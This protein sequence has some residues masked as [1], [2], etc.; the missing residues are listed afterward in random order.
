M[1]LSRSLSAAVVLAVLLAFTGSEVKAEIPDGWIVA[2]SEHFR[3][4]IPDR[5]KGDAERILEYAE[6]ARQHILGYT[7][8]EPPTGITFLLYDRASYPHSP[9]YA[10]S[11]TVEREIHMLA[12]SA[13]SPKD[14]QGW[15]D[16]RWYA[17]TVYHELAHI[18]LDPLAG[19]EVQRRLIWL[20]EGLPEYLASYHSTP[21]IREKHR[22]FDQEIRN[23]LRN[24]EASFLHMTWS[25]ASATAFI[26]FLEE[27]YGEGAALKLW[28]EPS[29]ELSRTIE[30]LFGESV[31]QLEER[32]LSWLDDT[33]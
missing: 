6:E 25:Y 9:A 27:T 4:A 8:V 29:G 19:S 15:M 21:E 3:V 5:H 22:A 24:G 20:K 23:L 12:P 30:S 2:E 17:S 1:P 11:D 26:R 31:A 10:W 18:A 32:W 13:Q 33:Y 7:G 14:R 16:D 28:R